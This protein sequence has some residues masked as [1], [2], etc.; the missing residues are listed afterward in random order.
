MRYWLNWMRIVW[1]FQQ[2]QREVGIRRR[3][4]VV[5]NS[6]T[7]YLFNAALHGSREEQLLSR[8]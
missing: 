1:Q 2:V 5:V 4:R 6:H 3:I 7:L 8:M